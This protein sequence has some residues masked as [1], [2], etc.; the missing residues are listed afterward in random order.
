MVPIGTDSGLPPTTC[1]TFV[2]GGGCAVRYKQ[3]LL[4]LL[5]RMYRVFYPYYK[6]V[7]DILWVGL[8]VMVRRYIHCE[9]GFSKVAHLQG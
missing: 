5:H 6:S 9:M 8:G 4:V 3:A 2:V 7:S 1:H